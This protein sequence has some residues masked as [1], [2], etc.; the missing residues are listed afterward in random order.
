MQ[1]ALQ[2]VRALSNGLG[3]ALFGVLLNVTVYSGDLPPIWHGSAFLVGTAFV[4]VAMCVTTC[5]P[6]IVPCEDDRLDVD[7][8]KG[9][10]GY[11]AGDGLHRGDTGYNISSNVDPDSATALLG[12]SRTGAGRPVAQASVMEPP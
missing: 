8:D 10:T 11:V 3:P 6:P 1:G 4:V 9:S 2:A 5:L 12:A 7:G